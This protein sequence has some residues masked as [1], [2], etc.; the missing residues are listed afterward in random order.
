MHVFVTGASGWV[1]S[2]VVPE[3]LAAGHTVTGLARSD[4][5]A[6]VVEA[7]GATVVRGTL[8]DHGLLREEAERADGVVHLAFP[9]EDMGDLAA[10]GAREGE[11]VAAMVAG[12]DGT[13]KPVVAASGTPMGQGRPSTE[14][15]SLAVG[16]VAVRGENEQRLLAGATRGFRPSV[17]RLPRSVHGEGDA[18]GFVAQ[19]SGM[20]RE[21]GSAMY[22]GDGTNRWCA[23]H[24]RDAARLFR[25]ALESAPAGAALHAVGDE[26]V[27]VR[28][29]A[30]ALA[31]RL[32]LP[33]LGDVD[34][35][36]LGFFGMMQTLDHATTAE[37][38]R[39]LMSWAPTHPTLLEDVAAGHYDR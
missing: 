31:A 8:E 16:P 32:D 1:A 21:A 33:V 4:A 9:H 22:V 15:D 35:E 11:A 30:E 24:V 23:V 38:T 5:S 37:R 7:R 14:E 13:G 18:H 17:V 6:A 19:L 26:G 3:L 2:A 36:R 12:L 27:P 25:L 34:P 29:I 28:A 39:A 20:F 10:A